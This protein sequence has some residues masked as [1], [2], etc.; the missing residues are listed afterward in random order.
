MRRSSLFVCFVV[1]VLFLASCAS[2]YAAKHRER[3]AV[4]FSQN[5]YDLARTEYAASLE[6]EDH[7]EAHAWI[8]RIL[9]EKKQWLEALPHLQKA[10]AGETAPELRWQ[11]VLDTARCRLNLGANAD[12]ADFFV[13]AIELDPADH[14]APVL[15]AAVWPKLD[16]DARLMGWL[17]R[18][19]AAQPDKHYGQAFIGNHYFRIGEME[20]AREAYEKALAIFPRSVP[21]LGAP[22]GYA[23]AT[24]RPE[25]SR[26]AFQRSHGD[27]G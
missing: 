5:Q 9:T 11:A 25:R 12:A 20:K 18:I 13:R 15:S 10:L 2:Q 8:G 4:Q 6:Y 26:G 22:G 24:R 19:V 16:S 21:V 17:D 7:P 3:G 27:P 14:T 1:A 23:S